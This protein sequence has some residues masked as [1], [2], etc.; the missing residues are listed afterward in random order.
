MENTRSYKSYLKSKYLSIKHSTY[1]NVYD[2]LFSKYKNKNITF[3]EI[4]VLSGGSLFMW[5]DF[6]GPKARIIGIDINPK[7]KKWEAYGF[8]IFIGSQSDS[9]FLKL[10]KSSL[11]PI[12]IILDDGGHTYDQQ[13]ITVETLI[14]N[15]KDGGLLVV[16]DTHTSYMSGFGPRKYSFINYTKKKIDEINFRFSE[17]EK[18]SERRIYSISFYESFVVFNINKTANIDSKPTTNNGITD[19][20]KDYRN[21]DLEN[22]LNLLIKIIKFLKLTYILK[23]TYKFIFL[24][25][26][27]RFTS[28]KYFK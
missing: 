6:F 12:D 13:I 17:F 4:G 18:D 19:L 20:A 2:E 21:A 8:E 10:I 1:F 9:E 3:L 15:I 23:S 16:E 11:G 27:F 28:K 24:D 26:I 14:N 5:R 22:K 7:A 25:S